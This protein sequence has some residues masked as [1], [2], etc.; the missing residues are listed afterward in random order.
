MR[1]TVKKLAKPYFPDTIFKEIGGQNPLGGWTMWKNS[2]FPQHLIT[3]S[4]FATVSTAKG[5]PMV[6]T[7]DCSYARDRHS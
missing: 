1:S 3:R 5:A 4:S 6:T 2:N 7:V